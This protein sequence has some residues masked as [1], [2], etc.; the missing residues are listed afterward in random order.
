MRGDEVSTVQ[1]PLHR[2]GSR[3]AGLLVGRRHVDLQRVNSALCI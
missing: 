3:F 1:H 2:G